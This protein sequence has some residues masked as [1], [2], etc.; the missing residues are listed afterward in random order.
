MITTTEEQLKELLGEAFEAG[1][2]G[3]KDLK[4]SVVE[5]LVSKA[6][7]MISSYKGIGPSTTCVDVGDWIVSPMGVGDVT[8]DIAPRL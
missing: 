6:V 8:V 2:Y 3:S 4:E 7:N 5:D 1:W